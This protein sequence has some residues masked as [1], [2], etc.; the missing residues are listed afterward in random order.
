MS[1]PNHPEC[2]AR[3][4]HNDF[5]LE[6]VRLI[7]MVLRTGS[8]KVAVMAVCRCKVAPCCTFNRMLLS[9]LLVIVYVCSRIAML[10][11]TF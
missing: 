2:K 11:D 7:S 4:M 1:I 9:Q 5:A 8:V 3:H 6:V 10:S